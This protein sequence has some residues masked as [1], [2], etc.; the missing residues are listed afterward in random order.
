LDDHTILP[1]LRRETGKGD[2]EMIKKT[3]DGYWLDMDNG[4]LEITNAEARYLYE[5][6]RKALEMPQWEN[7]YQRINTV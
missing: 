2:K 7:Q 6:L 3:D 4:V 5:Y 1:L